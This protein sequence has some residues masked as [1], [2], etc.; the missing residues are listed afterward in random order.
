[1][2]KGP[3]NLFSFNQNFTACFEKIPSAAIK[4]I[5]KIKKSFVLRAESVLG[6]TIWVYLKFSSHVLSK[7]SHFSLAYLVSVIILCF[8][9]FFVLW[10]FRAIKQD[11]KIPFIPAANKIRICKMTEHNSIHP[12]RKMRSFGWLWALVCLIKTWSVDWAF[13]DHPPNTSNS[14][15]A[16]QS[17]LE[18]PKFLKCAERTR[19]KKNTF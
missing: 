8:M 3:L 14:I 18:A 16:A 17:N 9:Y 15:E 11:H 6:D 2:Q 19:K 13:C 12:W 1:M 4:A 10:P 7:A 5:S